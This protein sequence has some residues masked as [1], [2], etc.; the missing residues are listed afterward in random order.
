SGPPP[1]R[2]RACCSASAASSS[3]KA[4]A[5]SWN[6]APVE[7]MR[8]ASTVLTGSP[9]QISP[10]S[11]LF[12]CRLKTICVVADA[13]DAV[14]RV[15]DVFPRHAGGVGVVGLLRPLEGV[16]RRLVGKGVVGH[17]PAPTP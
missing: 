9:Y 1:P 3:S 17:P 4:A 11:Q 5:F 15:V 10:L 13:G 6:E 2:A 8:V 12:D 14:A 16:G 7:S